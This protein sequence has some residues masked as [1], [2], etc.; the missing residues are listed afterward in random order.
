[1]SDRGESDRGERDKGTISD[2][3]K[4]PDP[5]LNGLIDALKKYDSYYGDQ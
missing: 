5:M 4:D 3:D 2:M 1:M